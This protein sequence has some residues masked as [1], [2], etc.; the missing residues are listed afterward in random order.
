M[1]PSSRSGFIQHS[2]ITIIL[3][4]E[5]ILDPF[6][7]DLLSFLLAGVDLFLK[8][9][10][11]LPGFHHGRIRVLG[12]FDLLIVAILDVLQRI[13]ERTAVV[14]EAVDAVL[15]P[16]RR[17]GLHI[18]AVEGG[19]RDRAGPGGFKFAA[20]AFVRTLNPDVLHL[21]LDDLGVRRQAVRAV[22]DVLVV[23]LSG[24]ELQEE[25]REL[26]CLLPRYGI[27]A[28]TVIGWFL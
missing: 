7:G 12:D 11:L 25:L 28:R 3:D 26:R 4:I 10:V 5:R 13:V 18:R 1:T 22:D 20:V 21:L 15:Q 17:T 19:Q 24:E 2:P 9:P 6:D 27:A 14:E 8:G 16:V 23:R